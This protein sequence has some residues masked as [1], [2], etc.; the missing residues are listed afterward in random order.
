MISPRRATLVWATVVGIFLIGVVGKLA[1]PDTVPSGVALLAAFVAGAW[2]DAPSTA[3]IALPAVATTVAFGWWS[4]GG[5][6]AAFVYRTIVV[7]LLGAMSVALAWVRDR[8]EREIV[9]ARVAAAEAD[10]MTRMSA[11][12]SAVFDALQDAFFVSGPDGVIRDVNGAFERMFGWTHEEVVGCQPPA[13]W[14]PDPELH[15]EEWAVFAAQRARALGGE[16]LAEVVMHYRHKNGH[17]VPVALNASVTRDAH[18]TV[19]SVVGTLRDVG[20][21]LRD[22]RRATTTARVMRAITPTTDRFELGAALVEELRDLFGATVASL[23]LLDE[24][25]RRLE[26]VASAGG[27]H[28]PSEEWDAIP[29][30][31]RVPAT[32][33]VTD[34]VT[35]VCRDSEA[36][37]ESFPLVAPGYENED[38]RS[39]IVVP[40]RNARG[41]VGALSISYD[42]D[43]EFD[44]DDVALLEEVRTLVGPATDRARLFEFQRTTATALQQSML[45]SA[46][47]HLENIEV[48]TR[49]RPAIE[50]YNVCG[51]WYDVITLDRGRLGIAVGDVVGRGLDAA[52]TM[53]KL[54]SALTLAALQGESAARV[55]ERLDA[56]AR[57]IPEAA[58]TTVLYAIV[59]VAGRSVEVSS[60]GHPPPIVVGSD[61][62]A[63][64][65]GVKPD[66]PLGVGNEPVGRGETRFTLADNSTFVCFTDGFV[67]RRGESLDDGLRRLCAQLQVRHARPVERLADELLVAMFDGYAQAD[68]VGLVIVRLPGARSTTFTRRAPGDMHHLAWL[69]HEFGEWL[70]QCERAASMRDDAVLAVDEAVTNVIEHAY[71]GGDETRSVVVEAEVDDD[72]LTLRVCDEGRW[73]P[74]TVDERRGRG[75]RIM[76]TVMDAVE[77]V[78]LPGGSQVVMRRAFERPRVQSMTS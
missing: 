69:R 6:G 55:L 75:L 40:V 48:A 28:Q 21:R 72:G 9:D 16:S 45:S 24:D 23:R 33:A 27:R 19:V 5:R 51:D 1:D 58:A 44:D 34:D 17:L 42:R 37:R 76:E 54:R 43:C 8:R 12:R 10:R 22:Q 7:V 63:E 67:E 78:R 49:Y 46:P 56:F 39:L 13:P 73:R 25:R 61:D 31:L 18:G 70:G 35:V 15:A 66:L 32:V 64:V 11:M 47:S 65:L 62:R 26:R 52:V 4:D 29:L 60:A 14:W 50:A 36:L 53:G 68:D 38:L 57:T 41:V 3:A 30:E 2:F 71:G 59:D 77:I 20:R 74:R